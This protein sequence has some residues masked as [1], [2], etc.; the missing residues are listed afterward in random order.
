[1]GMFKR[2]EETSKKV[3]QNNSADLSEEMALCI[4]GLV[5]YIKNSGGQEISQ[6]DLLRQEFMME[7]VE[8]SSCSKYNLF[9]EMIKYGGDKL[10]FVCPR[11][12]ARVDF[13]LTFE[14]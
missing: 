9:M 8:C 5:E 4:K 1:M 6:S 10:E 3:I 7:E 14:G 2:K 12:G 13:I 11:C